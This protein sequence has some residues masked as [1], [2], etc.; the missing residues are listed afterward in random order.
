MSS[1]AE[2][3]SAC[4]GF[5]DE[6]AATSRIS[7]NCRAAAHMNGGRVT[8]SLGTMT[9]SPASRSRSRPFDRLAWN[10]THGH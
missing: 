6:L 4:D 2:I 3:K 9:V 10:T 1:L 8:G 7:L 5:Y